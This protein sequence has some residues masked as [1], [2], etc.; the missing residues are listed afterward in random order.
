[1]TADKVGYSML[2]VKNA[3]REVGRE[4]QI[5]L[6]MITLLAFLALSEA[7]ACSLYRSPPYP[8]AMKMF[9]LQYELSRQNPEEPLL[10]DLL[11]LL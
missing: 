8:R 4:K 5:H 7:K 10:L 6:Q 11:G 2:R 1:M 9:E 3:R